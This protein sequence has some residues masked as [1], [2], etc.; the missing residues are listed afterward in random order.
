MKRFKKKMEKETVSIPNLETIRTKPSTN[1][2]RE[3]EI[4]YKN[5]DKI[6]ILDEKTYDICKYN[7]EETKRLL[8]EETFEIRKRLLG[9]MVEYIQMDI[10]KEKLHYCIK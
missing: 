2:N 7:Q 10:L 4:E 1:K 9:R 3:I 8:T 6:V 5:N